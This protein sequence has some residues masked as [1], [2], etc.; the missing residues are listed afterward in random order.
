M[1]IRACAYIVAITGM[2]L[3]GCHKTNDIEEQRYTWSTDAPLT[4]PYRLRLQR[5]EKGNLI[6]NSSFET[7]KINW[8]V[9]LS[10]AID[11]WQL[12]GNRLN[13]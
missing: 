5:F 7:G 3:S 9:G 2:L 11:G 13:G 1:K 10:F 8:I 12:V 4:I 6:R